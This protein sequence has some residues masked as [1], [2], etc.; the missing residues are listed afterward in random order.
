LLDALPRVER[1][2]MAEADRCCGS[3]GVYNLTHPN[4]ADRL[5]E[6]KIEA[7]MTA[8]ADRIVTANPGCQIHLSAASR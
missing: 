1:V 6:R 5:S 3:A 2:E 4:F 7:A 8:G